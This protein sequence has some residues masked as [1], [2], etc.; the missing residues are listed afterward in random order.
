M[1]D[2]N[3]RFTQKNVQDGLHIPP[4]AL[5]LSGLHGDAPMEYRVTPDTIVA[6][7]KRMTALEL[8]NVAN[9]LQELADEFFNVLCDVCGECSECKNECPYSTADFAMDI[10]LPEELLER[11]GIPKDAKLAA[12]VTAGGIVIVPAEEV[13][14]LQNVPGDLMDKLLSCDICPG[15]LEKL[16]MSGAVVY[17]DA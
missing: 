15:E 17:G 3:L 2:T 16:I 12:A 8:V 1:S 11:A 14:G 9:S 13:P 10:A 5:K 4:T 6:Y 7:K